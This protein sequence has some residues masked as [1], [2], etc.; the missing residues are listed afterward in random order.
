MTLY[1]YLFTH[2]TAY[3]FNVML[4]TPHLI[5]YSAHALSCGYSDDG[6]KSIQNVSEGVTVKRLDQPNAS[7]STSTN[8]GA[9]PGK[10]LTIK[11]KPRDNTKQQ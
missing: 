6:S 3:L 9:A 1:W 10:K 7:G 11:L 4:F 5:N 2:D 8:T